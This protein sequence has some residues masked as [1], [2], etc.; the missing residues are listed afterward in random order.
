MTGMGRAFL[1][2]SA[3]V[4][5]FALAPALAQQANYDVKTINFDLWCQEQAN[6]PAERCDKRLPEDEKDY[7]TFRNTIEKYEVS[8]LKDKQ[9]ERSFDSTI[10]H[11]DPIDEP[12][13]TQNS[14]PDVS[15][16]TNP[17]S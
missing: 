13:S 17:P 4:L 2:A 14:E 9:K 5:A 1:L 7:E 11:N 15:T 3:T 10:L 16:K 6:L 8:H 12:P